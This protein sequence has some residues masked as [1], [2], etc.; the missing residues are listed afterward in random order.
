MINKLHEKTLRFV[1]N[2][3]VSDFEAILRKSYY[4]SYHHRNIQMLMTDLYESK[5]EL[6]LPIM[7]SVLNRRSIR[8]FQ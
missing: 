3:H 2:D 6:G 4:I 8:N 1:L 7:N 5:N